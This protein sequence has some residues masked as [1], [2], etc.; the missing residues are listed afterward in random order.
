[1]RRIPENLLLDPKPTRAPPPPPKARLCFGC[2][3]YRTLWQTG[4]EVW[5][6]VSLFTSAAG[7]YFGALYF[8]RVESGL[9]PLSIPISPC[10]WHVRGYGLKKFVVSCYHQRAS[11]EVQRPRHYHEWVLKW[12]SVVRVNISLAWSKSR[13]VSPM[14]ML[15]EHKPGD[16]DAN[17]MQNILTQC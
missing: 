6:G 16:R 14:A 17:P 11:F 4:G 10:S 12:P 2:P 8:F 7:F 15:T 5:F 1:M 9:N 13:E 3:Q